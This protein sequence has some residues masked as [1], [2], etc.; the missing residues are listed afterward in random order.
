MIEV[1]LSLNL[2]YT[3]LLYRNGRKQAAG[4]S[5]LFVLLTASLYFANFFLDEF[6]KYIINEYGFD[7]Y[8]KAVSCIEIITDVDSLPAAMYMLMMF[9]NILNFIFTLQVTVLV[10]FMRARP[11]KIDEVEY[12]FYSSVENDTP[13]VIGYS[14]RSATLAHLRI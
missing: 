6:S 11:Y 13:V 2:I 10:A 8:L 5:I 3:L 9:S 7:G 1:L 14:F 12:L 4:L